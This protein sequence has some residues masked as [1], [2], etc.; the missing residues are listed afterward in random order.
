MNR[1]LFEFDISEF[2][3]FILHEID[4]FW[5][6]FGVPANKPPLVINSVLLR[7]FRYFLLICFSLFRFLGLTR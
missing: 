6:L 3:N 2:I 7:N 1:E 5:F 4:V